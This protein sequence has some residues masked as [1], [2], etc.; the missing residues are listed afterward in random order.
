MS[1]L[2][3]GACLARTGQSWL[4]GHMLSDLSRLVMILV[5]LILCTVARVV[6][7]CIETSQVRI[8][9]AGL[10]DS[11]HREIQDT[12][13]GSKVLDASHFP[14]IS[15]DSAMQEIGPSHCKLIGNSALHGVTQSV[16][17]DVRLSGGVYHTTSALKQ[18]AFDIKPT[19]AAGGSVRVKDELGIHFDGV[20]RIKFAGASGPQEAPRHR[21]PRPETHQGK[22][23]LCSNE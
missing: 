11:D 2:L 20:L 16:A 10:S 8:A 1:V 5:P 4:E 19:S 7:L 21:R 18:S 3:A 15:F 6:H 13:L 17:V 12:M 9:D 23:I 14:L 22:E